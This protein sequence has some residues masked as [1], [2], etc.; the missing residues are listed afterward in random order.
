MTYRGISRGKSGDDA[1]NKEAIIN[2]TDKSTNLLAKQTLARALATLKHLR[3]SPLQA[4]TYLLGPP[5]FLAHSLH[6]NSCDD[7]R[8]GRTEFA[9]C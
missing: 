3:L 2:M 8:D 4:F 9:A 1:E 7:Q 5:P 6:A